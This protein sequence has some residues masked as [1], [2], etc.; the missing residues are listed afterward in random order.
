MSSTRRLGAEDS[1]TRR[2]LLDAG[3]QLMLEDGYAGVTS[4]KVAAKAGLKPQLVH[5]YFRTMDELFVAML[6]RGAEYSLARQEA[7]FAAPRPLHAMWE[8]NSEPDG[9]ALIAEFYALAN[10]RPAIREEVAAYAERFREQQAAALHV[11][12]AE[13]GIDT[14]DLPPVVIP[15]L[16]TSVARVLVMEEGLGMKNGHAETRA[17]VEQWLDRLE[18]GDL[19]S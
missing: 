19:L 3:L 11:L 7:A 18:S 13:R 4:R 16:M 6:R 5:Y 2:K 8:F 17:I 9:V 12:L 1:A 14:G 10:H 15:V